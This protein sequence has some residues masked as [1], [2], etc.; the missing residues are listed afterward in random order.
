MFL[1]AFTFF[2]GF[3]GSFISMFFAIQLMPNLTI[4]G[5]V[6]VSTIIVVVLGILRGYSGLAEV[7]A[8][9]GI[10]DLSKKKKKDFKGKGKVK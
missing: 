8:P 5:F 3:F 1:E 10:I 7:S 6:G 9:R 2:I 4:G